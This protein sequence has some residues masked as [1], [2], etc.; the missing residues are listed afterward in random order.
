MER[1]KKF[2]LFAIAAI[3]VSL[4]LMGG[5]V[6][7]CSNGNDSGDDDVDVD[8]KTSIKLKGAFFEEG[9]ENTPW[10]YCSEELKETTESGVW[11]GEITSVNSK[12]WDNFGLEINGT[13][14]G[15]EDGIKEI[16]DAKLVKDSE[17]SF[18]LD[19]DKGGKTKVTVNL[20]TMTITATAESNS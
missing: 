16:K 20:N 4:C 1:K 15:A 18:W 5:G 14:Y 3:L 13:W 6:T 19:T 17:K 10:V 2:G 12:G 11:E 7:A 8:N 9:D